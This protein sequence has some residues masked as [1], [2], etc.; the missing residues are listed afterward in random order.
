MMTGY[1]NA[2]DDKKYF[3][4]SEPIFDCPK[5]CFA[6]S[7]VRT[8]VIEFAAYCIAQVAHL[9]PSSLCLTNSSC[10]SPKRASIQESQSFC[11]P[12]LSEFNRSPE[13]SSCNIL[14]PP[15]CPSPNDSVSSSSIN[16]TAP[17]NPSPLSNGENK[18]SLLNTVEVHQ[19]Q[20]KVAE[21]EVK[22]TQQDL[23]TFLCSIR[24]HSKLITTELLL[25]L[26]LIDTLSRLHWKQGRFALNR[27]NVFLVVLVTIM[28]A[29]KFSC[30]KPLPNGW[31]SR[32][33][34]APLQMINETEV[35]LLKLLNYDVNI[36]SETFQR[37][38]TA[39][40]EGCNA[41]TLSPKT[42]SICCL[43]STQMTACS[44]ASP[45]SSSILDSEATIAPVSSKLLVSSSSADSESVVFPPLPKPPSLSSLIST[46]T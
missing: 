29:H 40:V 46:S 7:C 23:T 12:T 32:T 31:W 10:V 9:T 39:I 35:L 11:S 28:I 14:T 4:E 27:D 13:I 6:T 8:P 36:S 45:A 43:R 19:D 15:V 17:M 30:D 22:K 37:Y 38:Y 20:N 5:I 42:T 25:S 26:S 2:T 44:T 33:F 16:A 1:I 21:F 34:N 3:N 18:K 24:Y 41:R